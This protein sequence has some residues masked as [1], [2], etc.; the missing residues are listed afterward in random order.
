MCI[1][2]SRLDLID[3]AA[4]MSG[5]SRVEFIM[6]AACN[7]AK[8]TILDTTVFVVSESKFDR[9]EKST[10]WGTVMTEYCEECGV[11]LPPEMKSVGMCHKCCDILDETMS[12][13]DNK[14]FGEYDKNTFDIY[15]E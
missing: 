5:T 9:F 3:A 11:L 14:R 7:K 2:K 15:K 6:S 1:Q 4:E 8:E 10:E 12:S 13:L